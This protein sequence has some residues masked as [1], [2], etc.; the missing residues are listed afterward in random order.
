MAYCGHVIHFG[1]KNIAGKAVSSW[2]GGYRD[3]DSIHEMNK[4]LTTTINKYVK[5]DDEL[6]HLGDWSFGGEENVAKFREQLN[7][8]NIHIIKGNHDQHI[9]KNRGLFS[10]VQTYWEGQLGHAQFVLFHYAMR[11]WYHS[12]KGVYHCYGHSH[13]SLENIP[14]GKSVDVGVDSA[15]KLFGEYRP[16]TINEVTNILDKRDVKIID[17]HKIKE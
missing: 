13:G 3:F 7:V 17:Q 16:F 4:C 5:W 15:Y 14:Y 8:Q 10:S 12:H 6:W 9:D 11:V 1:H 2:S